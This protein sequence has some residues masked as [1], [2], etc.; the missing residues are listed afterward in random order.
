MENYYNDERILLALK[1]SDELMDIL[2][3]IQEV[4]FEIKDNLGFDVLWDS[5]NGKRCIHV[6]AS[7]L[8]WLGYSGSVKLQKQAFLNL[9]DRNDIKYKTIDY[10]DELIQEF[11]EI[12]KEM[13]EIRPV[14][15]PRKRWLIM[16]NKNFKEAIMSLTTKR[17]KEIRKY[18][19]LLEEL[20]QLYGAYTHK[21][22]EKQF[23]VQLQSK[24]KQLQFKEEELKDAKEYSIVLEELMIKDE[25]K[26]K[27][28]VIY[29]ATTELYAKN[30]L[31][32][33]GG[34]DSQDKLKSRLST[35]NTGRIK[36]DLFYY[37]D[38]FMVSDYRQIESRLKDLMGRFRNK[39]EKEM[40]RLHYTDTRYIVDYLCQHYSDEVDEVNEKLSQFISN[41]NKRKLRPIVPPV[42]KG[43]LTLVTCLN[44]DGTVENTTIQSKS[45]E[46]MVKMYISN[47]N[48]DTKEISKKKVFDD[49]KVNKDR[50]NKFPVLKSILAQLRPE[51][52]LK[53]K[54]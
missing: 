22:K 17:S 7:L 2:T 32:K 35:Y 14:D 19:L 9:L 45:F 5:L 31:F 25:P 21:F 29:I 15:V 3:F 16:D 41:L 30:N 28:Q 50:R 49:L 10:Q 43:Y 4:D 46:E 33:L 51:I 8:E 40:Y 24:E 53:L 38:T 6:Y 37:S 39:K 20:V 27:T 11:P 36:E 34:V 42:L 13:E 54:E 52:N 26:T 1:K 23:Q 47:L 18:Y 12:L 48:S 44:K